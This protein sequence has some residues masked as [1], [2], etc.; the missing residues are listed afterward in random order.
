MRFACESSSHA[1][2]DVVV[3]ILPPI[4]PQLVSSPDKRNVDCPFADSD[5]NFF[6]QACLPFLPPLPPPSLRELSLPPS[7]FRPEMSKKSGYGILRLPPA[8]EPRLKLKV[9]P[10]EE[11]LLSLLLAWLVWRVLDDALG[12]ARTELVDVGSTS[13]VALSSR[14][15]FVGYACAERK[16]KSSRA[17]TGTG[18]KGALLVGAGWCWY[19]VACCGGSEAGL[20][21]SSSSSEL[22]AAGT[23]GFLCTSGD[24]LLVSTAS[25]LVTS[26]SSSLPLGASSSLS[27]AHLLTL[28]PSPSIKPI[29]SL[30]R[31]ASR[32]SK[33]SW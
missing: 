13:I 18:A 2:R 23:V 9:G 22:G 24:E 25:S 7:G 30:S 26:S 3:A 5:G 10:V 1:H 29:F 20:W 16:E 17:G 28:Q 4:S 12:V 32:S 14:L 27:V 6:N 33:A 8:P 21:C 31:K 15:W 19:C 11:R